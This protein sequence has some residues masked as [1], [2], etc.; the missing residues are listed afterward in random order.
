MSGIERGW[1][2]PN[3]AAVYAGCSLNYIREAMDSGALKSYR[4]PWNESYR[5][6][7][8]SDVDT[9]IRSWKPGARTDRGGEQ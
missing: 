2:C 7:H 5:T 9:W 1:L 8:T 4:K 3:E 6:V